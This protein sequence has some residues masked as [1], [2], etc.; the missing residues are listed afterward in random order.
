M[1]ISAESAAGCCRRLGVVQEEAGKRWTPFFEDSYERAA[2][3]APLITTGA[4]AFQLCRSTE[5][6]AGSPHGRA[7]EP[8]VNH[9]SQLPGSG[10]VTKADDAD[11]HPQARLVETVPQPATEGARI[12]RHNPITRPHRD[13]LKLRGHAAI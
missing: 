5:R 3:G 8:H 4:A 11:Y 13:L 9:L 1:K 10:R 12:R 7:L 6:T 2:C